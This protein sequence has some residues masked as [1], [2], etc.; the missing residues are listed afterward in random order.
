M[1]PASWLQRACREL[2][3][4]GMAALALIALG[5]A[6]HVYGVKPLE[7]KHEQVQA[8]LA[9]LEAQE[10]A[11]D[12]RLLRDAAPAARLAAFYRF[13]DRRETATALLEKLNALAAAAGI[14][15]RTAEYRLQHTGSRIERYEITLPLWGSYAGIRSFV[16]RAL[17]EIPV[18]SLDQI[19]FRRKQASESAVQAEAR[20]T[21]HLFR[22][23]KP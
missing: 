18:L 8:R 6:L 19:S 10:R 3:A 14:E 7:A 23:E 13:F 4:L 15:L 20:L 21:L 22:D 11:S 12:E 1:S 9:R 5:V 2:G 17:E 16:E